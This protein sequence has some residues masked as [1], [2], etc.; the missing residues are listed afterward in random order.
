MGNTTLLY[1]LGLISVNLAVINFLPLPVLDGGL[2]VMLLIEKIRGRPLSVKVQ[3]AIQ[4]V[5]ITLIAGIFLYVTI[6]NDLPSFFGH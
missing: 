4:L 3:T 6:F 1:F 5:G 2:F